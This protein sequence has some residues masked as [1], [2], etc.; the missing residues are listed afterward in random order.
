MRLHVNLFSRG[1]IGNATGSRGGG[2][3]LLLGT[4]KRIRCTGLGFA[5]VVI[6]RACDVLRCTAGAA[7]EGSI[8]AEG[9]GDVLQSVSGEGYAGAQFLFTAR[10]QPSKN[11][12]QVHR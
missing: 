11:E 5:L 8:I 6:Y 7:R 12:T 2:R 1:E 3:K 9:R 10:H 4:Q